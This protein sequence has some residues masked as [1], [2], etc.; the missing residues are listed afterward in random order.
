MTTTARKGHRKPWTVHDPGHC[1]GTAEDDTWPH[2]DTP[3]DAFV[4]I[5]VSSLVVVV[6]VM[7]GFMIS[8]FEGTHKRYDKVPEAIEL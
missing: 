2:T 3:N 4:A 1:V 8:W 5:L 6:F 7:I